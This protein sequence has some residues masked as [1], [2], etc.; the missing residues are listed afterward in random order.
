MKKRLKTPKIFECQKCNFVT[1][2]KY[3]YDK[4]MTT[5]KHQNTTNTTK[6]TQ[7]N[8]KLFECDC[9]KKYP[10]RSSLFNH[11][12][13]CQYEGKNQIIE[14]SEKNLDYKGMFLTIIKEN[15]QLHN[16]LITQQNQIS[17]LLPK[18]GN[19]IVGNNII[20]KNKI[21]INIFLNEQ[22][23]DALTMN[24]F[25]DKIKIT[26]DDLMVTKN[27]GLSEGVSNIFIE[28]MNKLSLH[29]RPMHCTDV[30]RE[31]VYIKCDDDVE[32]GISKWEKD[33]ENLKL[34]NALKKVSQVQQK[35]L[36]KWT[37]EHPN[38]ME[39][40]DLQE[41]YMKLVK[42]CTDDLQE[43]KRED[44]VIKKVCNKTYLGDADI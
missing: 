27:K 42:N 15:K 30:K 7:E 13:K 35:S 33:D 14:K 3:D 24:E 6:K 11:R 32:E 31:T 16:T 43:H 37:E 25:I 26:M 2:N 36:T 44:K 28:N 5:P 34:K 9:G 40:S 19:Q 8:A 4:H 20:N 41:E 17:E 38:W 10:Y 23:K 21:N 39:D 12:K 22:C 18:I 1:S 29:E